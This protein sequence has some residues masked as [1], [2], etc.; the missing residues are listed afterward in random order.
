MLELGLAPFADEA[1]ETLGELVLSEALSWEVVVL[2]HGADC[3]AGAVVDAG[4]AA[5]LVRA[6]PVRWEGVCRCEA[7]GM[8]CA[9]SSCCLSCTSS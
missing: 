1:T 5:T 9:R 6:L 2:E 3:G 4:G 7:E 8:L